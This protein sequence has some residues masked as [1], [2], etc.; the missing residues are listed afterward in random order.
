VRWMRVLVVMVFVGVACYTGFMMLERTGVST[1]TVRGGVVGK[2]H[3]AAHQTYV[4][5]IINGRS[6]VVPRT[7]SDAFVVDVATPGGRATG[8]VPQDLYDHLTV[9]DT[10]TLQVRRRR[11]SRA[12]DVL[13]VSR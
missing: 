12:I 6:V 8:V 11:L 13:H 1:T 2:R 5:E 4:T 7:V 9:G 3:V 10:L